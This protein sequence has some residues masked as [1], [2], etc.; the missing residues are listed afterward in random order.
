MDHKARDEILLQFLRFGASQ[1]ESPRFEQLSTSDWEDLVQQ[2]IRQGVTPLIYHRVKKLGPGLSVPSNVLKRLRES[3]LQSSA[4]NLRL[5]H[6]LGKLLLILQREDIP[7]I[8][9]KGAHLAEIVYGNIAVR[10]MADIDLLVRQE[11]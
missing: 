7:V 6:Q 10:P 9:L 5:Y 3:Y 8:L 2:S 11:D 4:R 1:R